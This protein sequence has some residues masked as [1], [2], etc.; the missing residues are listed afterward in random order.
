MRCT[1]S[2]ILLALVVGIFARPQGGDWSDWSSPDDGSDDSDGSDSPSS[3]GDLGNSIS[4]TRIAIPSCLSND[5][6][7]TLVNGYTYLLEKPGGPDFNSTANA[8]LSDQFTVW[9]D[10]INTLGNRTVSAIHSIFDLI[11]KL[12]I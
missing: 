12:N 6:V 5:D 7:Q 11:V 4:S 3:G 1:I 9:S 8:I 2:A 10:S